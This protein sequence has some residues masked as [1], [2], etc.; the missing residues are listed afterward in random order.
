MQ[1]ISP[2]VKHF[3]LRGL[4]SVVCLS[5][6]TLMQFDR[7]TCHLAGTLAGFNDALC[8][9]GVCDPQGEGEISG[10]EFL[11][12]KLHLPTYDSPGESIDQRFRFSSNDC[13]H[14]FSNLKDVKKT[15]KHTSKRNLFL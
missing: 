9:M 11:S 8:S 1:A 12:P 6:L 10:V 15:D 3:F 7:S 2:I 13:Y 4:S 5:S 14:L